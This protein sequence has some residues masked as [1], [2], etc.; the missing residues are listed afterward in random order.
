MAAT[1]DVLRELEQIW[2]A[3]L[4]AERHRR[5]DSVILGFVSLASGICMVFA[6]AYVYTSLAGLQ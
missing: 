6:L 3:T 4:R 5:I 1:N 2:L